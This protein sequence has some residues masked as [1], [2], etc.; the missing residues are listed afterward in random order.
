MTPERFLKLQCVLK[1]RQPDLTV[2]A[3]DLYE[4]SRLSRYNYDTTLFEWSY[5]EIAKRCR[6]KNL[7]YPP[8]T[9]DG[10]MATNPLTTPL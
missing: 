9:E 2:L 5:L 3:A 10:D 4:D 1:R 8:I 7:P 6:Q